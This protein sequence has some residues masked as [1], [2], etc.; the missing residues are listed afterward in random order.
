MRD[1]HFKHVS[2]SPEIDHAPFADLTAM[3]VSLDIECW[4]CKH[5][6]NIAPDQLAKTG[7]R[8]LRDVLRRLVCR[9]CGAD[10]PAITAVIRPWPP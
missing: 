9:A 5:W 1:P 3:G 10:V 6:V 4:A 7:A 8:C 2:I